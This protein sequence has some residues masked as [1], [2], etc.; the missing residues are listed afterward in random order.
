MI[1]TLNFM[2]EAHKMKHYPAKSREE[3][4]EIIKTTNVDT[5][6][7]ALQVNKF[8]IDNDEYDFE[9]SYLR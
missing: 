1:L 6:C 5:F 8:D 7:F 4:F 2:I 9:V 3:V